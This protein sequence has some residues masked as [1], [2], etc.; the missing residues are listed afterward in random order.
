MV[1]AFSLKYQ[2]E[3]DS[4]CSALILSTNG[5]LQFASS[6]WHIWRCVHI[7]TQT[8]TRQAKARRMW[9]YALI[10]TRGKILSFAEPVNDSL[11]STNS[12]CVHSASDR[13]EAVFLSSVTRLHCYTCLASA[14]LARIFV[15]MWMRLISACLPMLVVPHSL[16]C[17]SVDVALSRIHTW[18]RQCKSKECF[19]CALWKVGS[20]FAEASN[21]AAL[22][23]IVN[24]FSLAD[25]HLYA[26]DAVLR[27]TQIN[28]PY[29]QKVVCL[30][31]A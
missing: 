27:Q 22:K 30:A 17:L 29:M 4:V 13:T 8:Q 12:R 26:N 16:P 2:H 31:F 7:C 25:P 14:C 6:P 19:V 5:Q 23:Q 21:E 28:T 9:T 3:T 24:A 1:N 15:L 20:S 10:A 18:M 11:W